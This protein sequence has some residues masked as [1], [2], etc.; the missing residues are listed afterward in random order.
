MKQTPTA[1]FCVATAGPTVDGR[2]I[3]AQWLTEVAETYSAAE[4]TAMIWPSSIDRHQKWYNLGT[5]HSLKCEAVDGKTKLFAR[6]LP[7]KWMLSM[8]RDE[9]QKL[10]PSVEIIE[11]YASTG[12]CYLTGIAVT[13]LPASTGT[14]RLEFS[15]A[16]DVISFCSGE[17]LSVQA[18][19]ESFFSR[20]F[21]RPLS[22]PA[23]AVAT[24]TITQ[25]DEPVM[26]EQQFTQLIG[27]FT[28]AAEN[29]GKAVDEIKSFTA[30]QTPSGEA[31]RSNLEADKTA[32]ITV[33]QFTA[34]DGKV[35]QLIN[36]FAALSGEKTPQPTGEPAQDIPGN[37]V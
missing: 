16:P 21:T 7:N 3:K 25:S 18:E 37:L 30:K 4:Y 34:L 9:Q 6:F 10:F 19:K 8:N 29:M 2:E 17:P 12:K 15:G 32:G 26:N 31:D 22:P 28:T 11:N 36:A 24:P 5:I 27:A 20:L 1:W 33:E 23:E 13:D 14:E 35:D